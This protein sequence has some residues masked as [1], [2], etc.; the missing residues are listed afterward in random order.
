MLQQAAEYSSDLVFESLARG[1]EILQ[2]T[3][4]AKA[5]FGWKTNTSHFYAGS[6]NGAQIRSRVRTGLFRD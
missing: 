6:N 4:G 3:N 5:A 2:A 1:D